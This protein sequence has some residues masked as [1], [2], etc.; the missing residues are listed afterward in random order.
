MARPLLPTTLWVKLDEPCILLTE[1]NFTTPDS[2]GRHRYQ[3]AIVVRNDR[4]AEYRLDM[5]PA[6][7]AEEFRILGCVMQERNV[8]IFNPVG[9]LRDIADHLRERA[10]GWTRQLEPS[11]LVGRY[12]D[13]VAQKSLIRQHVSVSGPLVT[14]TR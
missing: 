9:Q 13:F 7:A 5:G 14:I 6:M 3:I 1:L 4:P 11:D 8:E 12:H 10:S 2:H